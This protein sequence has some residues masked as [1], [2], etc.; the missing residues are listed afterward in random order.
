MSSGHQVH[1]SFKKGGQKP[2]SSIIKRND[3][4]EV[5]IRYRPSVIYHDLAHLAIESTLML[6]VG[7]Y[8]LI[9]LGLQPSD[10]ELKKIAH[11]RCLPLN[12]K[13]CQR[14]DN[15]NDTGYH[16]SVTKRCL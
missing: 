9:N 7:F 13:R 10:F 1:I 2:A 5:F 6:P 14:C 11:N 3:G 8:W 16:K 15:A 12:Y 4:T